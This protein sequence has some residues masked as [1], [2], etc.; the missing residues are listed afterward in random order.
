MRPAGWCSASAWCGPRCLS[1]SRGS[2]AVLW[3]WRL[4]G[5]RTTGPSQSWGSGG[6]RHWRVWVVSRQEFLPETGAERAVVEGA[7]DLEQQI[8]PAPG[9]AHL[10]SKTDETAPTQRD[11]HLRF[12]AE[13]GRMGWQK[14]SGYNRRRWP[15]LQSAAS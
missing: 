3:R 11:A 8:G 4:V 2:R 9:P 5:G 14:A 15:R 13:H 10:P 6:H 1:F 7:A 12:I